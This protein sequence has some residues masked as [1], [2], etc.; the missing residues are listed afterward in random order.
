MTNWIPDLTSGRGPKARILADTIGADISSGKL[1]PGDRLPP[2]RELAWQLGLSVGTITRAYAEARRRGL[3]NGQVGSGTY[4]L[5]EPSTE[6]AFV[7]PGDGVPSLTDLSVDVYAT[8]LWSEALRQTFG[9]MATEDNAAL[10]E[11]QVAAG[12]PRHR[13]VGAQW[14]ARPVFAPTADDVIVTMGGQHGIA[15][16]LSALSH[17][18]DVLLIEELHY[19]PVRSVAEMLGVTLQ[20]VAIDEEGL[21]P[22]ALEAA[23]RGAGAPKLLYITPTL[24]NP[25]NAVMGESRRA[26]IAEILRRYGVHAIEDDVTGCLVADPLPPI[27]SFARENVTFLASVSKAMA[28]GL[29]T[30][31]LVPPPDRRSRMLRRI[32]ALSW[33]AAAPMVEITTRWM[34]DGTAGRLRREIEQEH[35]ARHALAAAILPDVSEPP[36]A[37]RSPHMWYRLPDPWR[38]SEFFQAAQSSGVRIACTRSFAVN[39]RAGDHVRIS[40]CAARS[41]EELQRAL[42]TLAAI[43]RRPPV[44]EIEIM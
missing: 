32:R 28:P 10:M 5:G 23:C 3:V 26:A 35:R 29:R 8:P 33:F 2:Q 13:A 16:A 43:A 38:S 17:P 40:L 41:R 20:G 18:G 22:E 21:V 31:Y 36:F 44:A 27:A 7:L 1:R 9:A 24:Q 6:S 42:E 15:A 11:Y 12:L 34:E 37:A 14:I 39:Q 30:G 25:T 4:V 19:P